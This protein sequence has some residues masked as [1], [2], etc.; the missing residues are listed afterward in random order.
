MKGLKRIRFMRKLNQMFKMH[1]SPD[2][3]TSHNFFTALEKEEKI[4]FWFLISGY[5]L[6]IC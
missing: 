2:D 4:F 3:I 5:S 1:S 6:C